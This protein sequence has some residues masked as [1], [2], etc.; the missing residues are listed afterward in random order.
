MRLVA[1]LQSKN[2]RL[3]YWLPLVVAGVA[4][5]RL[6]VGGEPVPCEG[7]GIVSLSFLAIEGI[8]GKVEGA[9]LLLLLAIVVFGVSN[10][11]AFLGQQT[12]LPALLYVLLAVGTVCR[13]GASDYL[14]AAACLTAAVGRL[15]AAIADTGRNAPL[16]D[17]GALTALT[18]LLCPKLVLLLPW[19]VLAMPLTG[20]GE[21]R[22]FLAFLVGVAAMVLLVGVYYFYVGALAGVPDLFVAILEAG[23]SFWEVCPG[24][25]WAFAVLAVLSLLALVGVWGKSSSMA[26]AQRRGIY[27][28]MLLFLFLCGSLFFIPYGSQEVL[29]VVFLPASYLFSRHVITLRRHWTAC[30]FFLLL[31]GVSVWLVF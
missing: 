30:V 27:S 20:R 24:N 9:L 16:F 3:L 23:G 6:W 21:V 4:G 10:K 28:I 22:D 17:F 11:Y 14:W 2:V 15:Q 8:W 1:L 31:V 12:A 18:V 7:Q 19:A 26:I 5:V 13:Y 29:S 25:F